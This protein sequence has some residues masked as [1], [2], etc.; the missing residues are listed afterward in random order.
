MSDPAVNAV[1][2]LSRPLLLIPGGVSR[3][4]AFPRMVHTLSGD[5]ANRFGG[6]YRVDREDRF[7]SEADGAAFFTL[8][9]SRNFGTLERNAGE[10]AHA[11]ECIRQ[12][13]G[14][15]K[16]DVVAECKGAIEAR[17]YLRQGGD[18]I[19]HL[20]L[21][22]PPNHGF[23]IGGLLVKLFAKVTKLLHLPIKSLR[24]IPLDQESLEALQSFNLEINIGPWHANKYLYRLNR[25]ENLANERARTE[26]MTIIGGDGHRFWEGTLG[27]G[28]WIPFLEGDQSVPRWSVRLPKVQTYFVRGRGGFHAKVQGN[29]VVHAKIVE[30]LTGKPMPPELARELR[31]G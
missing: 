12:V 22:V 13:T 9:Y 18:H 4:R 25:P 21:L 6:A 11:I 5:G 26:S 27:P 23:P 29:P 20:I 24:G 7:R 3:E 17:E 8:E 28:F 19:G 30:I 1:P 10:I 16:V 2:P 31:K 14:S 15:E